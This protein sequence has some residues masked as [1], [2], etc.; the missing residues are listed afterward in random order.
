MGVIF[1][2]MS[3]VRIFCHFSEVSI[4]NLFSLYFV[5]VDW[6]TTDTLLFGFIR[7]IHYSRLSHHT[8]ILICSTDSLDWFTTV[9]L[10]FVLFN[11]FTIVMLLG[12]CFILFCWTGSLYCHASW[13]QHSLSVRWA[14]FWD[15]WSA[16]DQYLHSSFVLWICWFHYITLSISI[17]YWHIL[18][19]SVFLMSKQGSK[20]YEWAE[21]LENP[22]T[23]PTTGWLGPWSAF[24]YFGLCLVGLD[25][26]WSGHSSAPESAD[27]GLHQRAWMLVHTSGSSL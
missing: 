16:G 24:P 13:S 2:T 10:Y 14:M 26:G 25:F 9:R 15:R 23:K 20:F 18:W 4:F 7:L 21:W 3:D 11:G 12:S 27:F 5:L 19:Q 8:V 6:L 1:G 17:Y 22:A